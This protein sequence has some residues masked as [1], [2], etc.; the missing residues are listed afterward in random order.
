MSSRQAGVKIEITPE[1]VS[2]ALR[3]LEP[4]SDEQ[5]HFGGISD[6]EGMEAALRAALQVAPLSVLQA[7]KDGR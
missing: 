5:G 7:P 6:S 2:A 1:M 3:A 4:F